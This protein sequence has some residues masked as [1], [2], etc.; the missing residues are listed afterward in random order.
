MDTGLL[1]GAAVG[2]CCHVY[3]VLKSIQFAGRVEMAVVVFGRC[4]CIGNNS[5][6]GGAPFG[7]QLL[8]EGLSSRAGIGELAA[9]HTAGAVD[10]QDHI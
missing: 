10:D 4:V 8:T 2:I 5:D 1:V 6:A 7:K 9:L 3:C